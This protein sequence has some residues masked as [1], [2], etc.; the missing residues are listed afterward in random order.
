MNNF[1]LVDRTYSEITPESAEDGDFSDTGLISQDEEYSFSELVKLMK[2]HPQASSSPHESINTW[3]STGYYTSDY[4]TCTEREECIHFSE[5][6]TP[7]AA[8]Y[9]KLARIIANRKNPQ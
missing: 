5:K 7:N 8:K 9:W 2:G 1:I 4:R 3:Y 6:N